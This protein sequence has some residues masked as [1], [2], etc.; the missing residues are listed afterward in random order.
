M[1]KNPTAHFKHLLTI[2]LVGSCLAYSF[3]QIV[4][5]QTSE[6]ISS[7]VATMVEISEKSVAAGDIITFT[8]NGYK[9]S[10]ITYDT[11]IYGVVTE[12]PQIVLEDPTSSTAR[13]VISVGKVYV[14][15][16]TTGG[17]IKPGDLITSS[18]IPGVGQKAKE[19]GYVLGTA[20]ESYSE[21]D[22]Q[23]VGMI[24]VGLNIGFNS[25]AT[26][27]S[28]NL[29]QNLKLALAAP[30]VS[31]VNALRY[32]LAALIVLIGFIFGVGFFG[33]VSATGVE[34]I[35]RNPL[36]SRLI[37]LSMI[38][39]LSLALIIILVGIAIAYLILVL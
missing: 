23:K 26:T 30:E 18:K 9:K 4:S 32:I 7:G 1:L 37:M 10:T 28:S 6:S 33:R 25:R 31:P 36:A 17:E 2:L 21:K 3:T 16:T 11:H 27:I 15:V 5:A 19:S 12:N 8:E 24:L 13:P 39:H 38:F 34:A 20:L 14:K 35:G 22:Q 29:L